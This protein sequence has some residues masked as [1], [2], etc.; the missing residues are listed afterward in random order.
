MVLVENWPFLHVFILGNGG[1]E[2]LVY[3][4]LEGKNACL[5]YKNRSSKSRNIEIFPKELADGFGS[6]LVI[7]ACI[8]FR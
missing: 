7:F 1:Q 8:Y 3:D 5:G 4:F 6:K 2:N